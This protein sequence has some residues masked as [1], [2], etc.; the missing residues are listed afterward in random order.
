[1]AGVQDSVR[2]SG[3]FLSTDAH[4]AT[5]LVEGGEEEV[6]CLGDGEWGWERKGKGWEKDGLEKRGVRGMDKGIKPQQTTKTSE[7]REQ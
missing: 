3:V 6:F 5:G 1:M 7:L 4:P 2:F